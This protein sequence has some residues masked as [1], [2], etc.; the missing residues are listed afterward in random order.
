MVRKKTESEPEQPTA[1]ASK[2]ERNLLFGEFLEEMMQMQNALM[3]RGHRYGQ[4]QWAIRVLKVTPSRLSNWKSG[5]SIPD[6]AGLDALAN[7]LLKEFNKEAYK[8]LTTRQEELAETFKENGLNAAFIR[9]FGVGTWA[10]KTCYRLVG[11]RE[12]LPED[13]KLNTMLDTYVAATDEGRRV[14]W[15][16]F[17]RGLDDLE[18]MERAVETTTA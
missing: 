16:A 18:N 8:K 15:N 9:K 12:P 13:G 2:I 14:L 1:E 7:T 11:Q 6:Q 10:Y 4:N 17:Q 5:R 3:P